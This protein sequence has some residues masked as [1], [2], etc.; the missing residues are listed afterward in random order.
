MNIMLLLVVDI[1]NKYIKRYYHRR[2]SMAKFVELMN[3][4]FNQERF[5]FMVF[6]N[7]LLKQYEKIME[8][9]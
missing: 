9:S 5:R 3:T 1:R 4:N 7:T 2:L 8:Q 6:V